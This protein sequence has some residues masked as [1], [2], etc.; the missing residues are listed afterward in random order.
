MMGLFLFKTAFLTHYGRK[1]KNNA[2][3]IKL[4]RTHLYAMK[5]VLCN[6][7]LNRISRSENIGM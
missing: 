1:F 4:G 5:Y 2:K 3:T 6:F 7:L